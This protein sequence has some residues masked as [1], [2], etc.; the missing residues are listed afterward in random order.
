MVTYF[1]NQI[2]QLL[3]HLWPSEQ[4]LWPVCCYLS[5]TW[6]LRSWQ[7]PWLTCSMSCTASVAIWRVSSTSTFS[8]LFLSCTNRTQNVITYMWCVPVECKMYCI[9]NP[10]HR[11]PKFTGN[12][13]IC[14]ALFF[15]LLCC[16]FPLILAWEILKNFTSVWPV[17][18]RYLCSGHK[19]SHVKVWTVILDNYPTIK[20]VFKGVHDGE[21]RANGK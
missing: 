19:T 17:T 9:F 8:L 12:E 1:R 15:L 21:A 18:F 16:H 2:D 11:T 4:T 3:E 20:G 5:R 13:Q 7:L 14:T 10:I 6:T